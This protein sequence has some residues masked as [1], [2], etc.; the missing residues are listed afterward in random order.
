ML[1]LCTQFLLSLGDT[2]GMERVNMYQ[3]NIEGTSKCVL[4]REVVLSSE[5]KMYQYNREGTSKCVL[6]REVFL[7]CFKVSIIGG[8]TV[9]IAKFHSMVNGTYNLL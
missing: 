1:I 3:Y 6:N 4:Y 9:C 8:P 2:H 7:Y 5:V